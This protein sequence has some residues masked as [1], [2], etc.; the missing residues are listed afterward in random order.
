MFL[1]LET[2]PPFYKG[3]VKLIENPDLLQ[4]LRISGYRTSELVHSVSDSKID[5]SYAE[6]KWTVREVLC[7][8]IDAERIFAYRALRFARNDKTNLAGFDEK[9]YAKELNAN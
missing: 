7:H 1:N 5:Y 4:A 2:I 9:E 3:Y 8:M 6:G